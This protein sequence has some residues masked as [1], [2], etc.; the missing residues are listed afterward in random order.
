MPKP[1]VPGMSCH[2][3]LI[4]GFPPASYATWI[5][6]TYVKIKNSLFFIL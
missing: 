4:C 6:I 3:D 1:K 2:F 5:Q